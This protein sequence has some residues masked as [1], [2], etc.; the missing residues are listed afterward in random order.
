[1]GRSS[2]CWDTEFLL[3]CLLCSEPS[4]RSLAFEIALRGDGKPAL[5]LLCCIN[6]LRAH[7]AACVSEESV[8]AVPP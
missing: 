5:Y 8:V 7:N 3:H 2:F 6:M 4:Q 1:M